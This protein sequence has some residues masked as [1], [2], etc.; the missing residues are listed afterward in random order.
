MN[1]TAESFEQRPPTQEARWWVLIHRLPPEPPYVR[2]KVRRRLQR[3]GAVPLKNTVYV[4]PDAPSTLEDFQWLQREIESDGGEAIV[5][6]AKLE[7]GMTDT[8]VVS[9]FRAASDA[10]YAE[11]VA[12]MDAAVD[13][14]GAGVERFR[15]Q[16]AGI[17]SRDHFAASGRA[18]VM[19]RLRRLESRLTRAAIA[20]EGEDQVAPKGATWVTRKDVFV[21]RIASAWLIRR[22]ID[23]SARFVFVE[24]RGYHARDGELQFDMFG[25]GFTHRGSSCTFETLL[26]HFGLRDP[27]L[28]AIGEIVHD[29]DLKDEKFGRLETPVLAELV[30]GI[31]LAHADDE[32]RVEAG[33]VLFDALYASRRAELA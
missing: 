25:V 5:L 9:L 2:V 32:A 17:E 18:E 23:P 4:L 28:S 21:D 13:D 10:E 1:I 7:G 30:R 29:L 14:E 19:I 3:L 6:S 24:P 11:L 16:L 20:R 8:D 33:A 31:T 26:V 12:A 22:F 27:G 15:R